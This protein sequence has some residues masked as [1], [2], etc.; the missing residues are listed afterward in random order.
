MQDQLVQNRDTTT[1]R[2]WFTWIDSGLPQTCSLGGT[3]RLPLKGVANEPIVPLIGT[4]R[5]ASI[6]LD[7]EKVSPYI[8]NARYQKWSDISQ[9]PSNPYKTL[10][11]S[12]TVAKVVS[13]LVQ[14][15]LVN[16]MNTYGTAAQ[17]IS[18]HIECKAGQA[19]WCIW[20]GWLKRLLSHGR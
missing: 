18:S 20:Y 15:L 4:A 8:W 10:T 7:I 9:L 19:Y 5:N 2:M 14:W 6:F 11:P 13:L 1:G 16:R 12:Y 17:I 3:N